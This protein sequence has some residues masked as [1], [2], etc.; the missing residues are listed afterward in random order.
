MEHGVSCGASSTM[1]PTGAAIPQLRSAE[2]HLRAGGPAY[3]SAALQNCHEDAVD[4]SWKE[5]NHRSVKGQAE[6]VHY[7]RTETVPW[8]C[9][10]AY[11]TIGCGNKDTC[12]YQD[13]PHSLSLLACA[14]AALLSLLRLLLQA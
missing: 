1:G 12:A 8:I 2:Y 3:E 11:Q 13:I 7:I 5:T 14:L 6:E 10:P 9:I 4:A